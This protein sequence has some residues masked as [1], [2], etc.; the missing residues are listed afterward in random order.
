MKKKI[1][2]VDYEMTYSNPSVL[3][4]RQETFNFFFFCCKNLHFDLLCSAVLAL[5][6]RFHIFGLGVTYRLPN[7]CEV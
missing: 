2:W 6:L 4:T 1:P 3:L 7:V 5:P